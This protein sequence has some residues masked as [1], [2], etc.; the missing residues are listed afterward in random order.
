VRHS[1]RRHQ[2]RRAYLGCLAV[3]AV[4]ASLTGPTLTA[5]SESDPARTATAICRV[6]R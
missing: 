2:F 1:P 6:D 5:T 4:S 3:P